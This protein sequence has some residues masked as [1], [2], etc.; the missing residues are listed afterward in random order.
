MITKQIENKRGEYQ[1]RE[2][3][4]DRPSHRPEPKWIRANRAEIKKKLNTASNEQPRLK[5]KY[6]IR[7]QKTK[8]KK[9]MR[10]E[11]GAQR[12]LAIGC[13][14]GGP[15]SSNREAA[16]QSFWLGVDWSQQWRRD[17]SRSGK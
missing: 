6:E 4:R 3:K 1:D 17:E 2:K 7:R 10:G 9:R 5:T 12:R 15:A 13:A 14:A 16:T 11:V 8:K